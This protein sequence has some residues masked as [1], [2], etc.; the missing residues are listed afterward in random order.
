VPAR[1]VTSGS[2]V[3][4]SIVWT[5]TTGSTAYRMARRCR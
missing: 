4:S 2:W 3:C 1:S 5:E